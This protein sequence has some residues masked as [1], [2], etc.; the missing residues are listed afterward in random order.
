MPQEK[1]QNEIWTALLKKEIDR[2]R[3]Y[4]MDNFKCIKCG[5][6]E[7]TTGQFQA[8]GGTFSKLFDVQNQKFSTITCTKCK[9]TEIYKATT[10]ELE[11]ILDFI[12]G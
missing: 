4:Q 7:Y 2:N 11:N 5:N 1:M 9:F 12:T 6:N 8:T 10:D 3:G